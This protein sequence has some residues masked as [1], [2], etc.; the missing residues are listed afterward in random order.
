MKQTTMNN[1]SARLEWDIAPD[2]EGRPPL[3]PTPG[4]PVI[5]D[6]D[7]KYPLIMLN[8]HTVRLWVQQDEDL[9]IKTLSDLSHLSEFM[10]EVW[11]FARD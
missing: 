4:H 5:F 10:H 9:A 7:S 3:S 6:A 2:P 1:A 8:S 11:I